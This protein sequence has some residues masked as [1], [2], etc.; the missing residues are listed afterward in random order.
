MPWLP[1]ADRHRNAIDIV[2][3]ARAVAAQ[4]TFEVAQ[5]EDALARVEGEILGKAPGWEACDPTV[6]PR[7]QNPYAPPLDSP[8]VTQPPLAPPEPVLAS[9]QDA[10]SGE[11]APSEPAPAKR[12]GK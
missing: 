6:I 3:Q 5:F 7:N 8:E 10:A 12:R 4:Y 2:H 1:L 11:P 9:D